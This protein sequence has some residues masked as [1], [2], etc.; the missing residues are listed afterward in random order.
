MYLKPYCRSFGSWAKVAASIHWSIPF[1]STSVGVLYPEPPLKFP[2]QMMINTRFFLLMTNEDSLIIWMLLALVR[3]ATVF[4]IPYTLALANCIHFIY[5]TKLTLLCLIIDNCRVE[6]RGLVIVMRCRFAWV[7]MYVRVQ[8]YACVCIC[9]ACAIQ[10]S[11]RVCIY[12]RHALRNN[13]AIQ[14]PKCASGD[15]YGPG[16]LP[17]LWARILW[18]NTTTSVSSPCPL[19]A[20]RVRFQWRFNLKIHLNVCECVAL[21]TIRFDS[22]VV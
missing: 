17:G 11:A 10:S 12:L 22:G 1:L 14:W 8:F 20:H 15:D 4:F 3:L 2:H 16:L 21:W 13:C 18:K 19:I 6:R 9:N 5:V 7:C